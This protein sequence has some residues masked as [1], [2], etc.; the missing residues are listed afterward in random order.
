M[1]TGKEKDKTRY[2]EGEERLILGG[3]RNE[4]AEFELNLRMEN[5][6]KHLKCALEEF[7]ELQNIIY[8]HTRKK[9]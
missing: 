2:P 9:E 3:Q 8:W 7:V 6:K 1:A 4:F 5:L